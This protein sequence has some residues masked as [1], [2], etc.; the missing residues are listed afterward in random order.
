MDIILC[1]FLVLQNEIWIDRCCVC[2][3]LTRFI[4]YPVCS[5]LLL[6]AEIAD[7]DGAW[8]A[9][10]VKK[11]WADISAEDFYND[12]WCNDFTLLWSWAIND[13]VC[14]FVDLVNHDFLDV[15]HVWT[16]SS[17]YIFHKRSFDCICKQAL[18]TSQ[19]C[20]C[21]VF[22]H[23]LST[24]LTICWG[25]KQRLLH[26][27]LHRA[28]HFLFKCVKPCFHKTTLRDDWLYKR[29]LFLLRRH[30]VRD[31]LLLR[32]DGVVYYCQV[33]NGLEDLTQEW[34]NRGCVCSLA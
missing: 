9:I 29:Y 22:K 26:A 12:K 16:T 13:Q 18:T 28:K 27:H 8:F 23:P 7:I 32:V 17:L 31:H 4:D 1:D 33:C 25:V 15:F 5:Q 24:F 11:H 19:N 14:E 30:H 2:W 3:L 20:L 21:W 34:D 10:G 6:P